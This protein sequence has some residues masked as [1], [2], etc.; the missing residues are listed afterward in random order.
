[1]AGRNVFVHD[2]DYIAVM[3]EDEIRGKVAQYRGWIESDRRRNQDTHILE[4]E[5][6]YLAEELQLRETRK[7][8]HTEF[9]RS[10]PQAFDELYYDVN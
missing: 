2:R 5:Y 7:R 3:P 8:A 10:N 6:C 9:M 1:M 4:V